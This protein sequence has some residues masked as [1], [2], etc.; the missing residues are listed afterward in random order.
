MSSIDGRPKAGASWDPRELDELAGTPAPA[1]QEDPNAPQDAHG[2]APARPGPGQQAANVGT[3]AGAGTRGAGAGAGVGGAVGA[4]GVAAPAAASNAASP[5]SADARAKMSG[6]NTLLATPPPLPPTRGR[7]TQDTAANYG[8]MMNDVGDALGRGTPATNFDP[9]AFYAAAAQHDTSTPQ[10]QKALQTMVTKSVYS[11]VDHLNAMNDAGMMAAFLELNVRNQASG[12]ELQANM[13]NLS[14]MGRNNAIEQGIKERE[15]QAAALKK[16]QEKQKALGPVMKLVEVILLAVTAIATVMTMGSAGPLLMA[17]MAAATLGGGIIGGAVKGAKNGKGFDLSGAMEG[18]SIGMGLIGVGGLL[19]AIAT[20]AQK[21][22]ARLAGKKTVDLLAKNAGAHAADAANAGGKAGTTAGG[23][24]AARAAQN[25]ADSRAAT[26]MRRVSKYVSDRLDDTKAA[27]EKAIGKG[28][29]KVGAAAAPDGAPTPAAG[30]L[31][32]VGKAA[33]AAQSDAE[34]STQLWAR[35]A[36]TIAPILSGVTQGVTSYLTKKNTI[37]AQE[38]EATAKM[39]SAMADAMQG[40]W[41]DIQSSLQSIT[42]AH[43]KAV[44][45]A[46]EMVNRHHRT[47]QKAAGH[48]AG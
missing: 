12:K 17:A 46:L 32:Q 8:S 35:N 37:H 21:A 27:V 44:D 16:A 18:A 23:S 29:A 28:P 13:L 22:L 36:L 33:Q 48:I 1:T 5:L 7:I 34:A 45:Q 31:A 26:H 15:A 14:T 10:G 20:V 3:S 39:Y 43:N 25:L 30:S 47:A 9:K 38:H 6:A 42:D 24:T 41:E 2:G 4:S 11:G 19:K 40:Q